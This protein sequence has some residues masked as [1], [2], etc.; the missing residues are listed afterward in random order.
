LSLV[1][2]KGYLL[3]YL[4][5]Y[6]SLN[7]V[8]FPSSHLLSFMSTDSRLIEYLA[9]STVLGQS[10]EMFPVADHAFFPVHNTLRMTLPFQL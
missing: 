8:F 2:N 6:K 4:L 1:T 7:N 10:K 3:T 9:S 5:R